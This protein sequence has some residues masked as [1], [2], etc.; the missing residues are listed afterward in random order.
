MPVFMCGFS[1]LTSGDGIRA[2]IEF[3]SILDHPGL[4]LN[5]PIA[6][7]AGLHI[8]HAYSLSGRVEDAKLAYDK[9]FADWKDADLDI[10]L[11]E[12]AKAEYAKLGLSNRRFQIRR[13]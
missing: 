7:A 4:A 5:S 3:Q 6:P 1:Y 8:G 10:P 2:A 9:F 11:L 13:F 12:Q